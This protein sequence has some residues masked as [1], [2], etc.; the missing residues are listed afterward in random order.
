M[1]RKRRRGTRLTGKKVRHYMIFY[2]LSS[3]IFQ[4]QYPKRSIKI[5]WNWIIGTK[6]QRQLVGSCQTNFPLVTQF[7]FFCHFSDDRVGS[8]RSRDLDQV[9]DNSRDSQENFNNN[10]RTFQSGELWQKWEGVL[11][12]I[13]CSGFSS[14]AVQSSTLSTIFELICLISVFT[15]H[16]I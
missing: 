14:G 4:I 8:G 11:Y 2:I 9:R 3:P 7:N 16:I 12:S 1:T 6:D 10:R 13:S 5:N 15:K